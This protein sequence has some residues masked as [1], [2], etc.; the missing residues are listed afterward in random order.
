MDPLIWY[1]DDLSVWP[2]LAKSYSMLNDTTL[3]ITTRD[4]I[5]W[6]NDPDN[7]FPD[8]YFD[9]EDVYF[10]LYAWKYL[11]IDRE[12]YD[13]IKDMEIVDN[14]TMKIFI[15]GD[16][17]TPENE[18]MLEHFRRLTYCENTFRGG[19]NSDM[20]RVYI[21]YGPPN[22]I[23]RDTFTHEFT[24]PVESWVY[25]LEG[26]VEFF[27]VDRLSDGN[28]LL[29]HSTHVDEYHNENWMNEIR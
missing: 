8:E 12:D 3:E 10:T 4:G 15:D 24:K 26:T 6:C 23:V 5:K 9:I 27:F 13:W 20:G 2:H 28:Y 1:D 29:V 18:F 16:P 14:N 21:Q 19:I 25:A 17:S 22:D 7:L 11:S